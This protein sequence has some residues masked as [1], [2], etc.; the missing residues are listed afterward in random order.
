[1]NYIEESLEKYRII[2]GLESKEEVCHALGI[3]PQAWSRAV[4]R[5]YLTNDQVLHIA[6][7]LEEPPTLLLLAR[8]AMREKNKDVSKF[9]F[10]AM[11]ATKQFLFTGNKDYRK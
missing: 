9:Y 8:D 1:M 10:G 5:G 6:E 4:K 11:I 7:G 2:K 3:K